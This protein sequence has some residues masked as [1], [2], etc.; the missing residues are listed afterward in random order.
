[1]EKSNKP[2]Y[3]RKWF[4]GVVVLFVFIALVVAFGEDEV[5]HVDVPQGNDTVGE[6]VEG[7]DDQE[8]NDQKLSPEDE[9]EKAIQERI[10]EGDY[11]NAE[12]TQI[13]VN[14]NMGDD[15]NETYI[16]LV[17]FDFTISNRIETGNDV[18]GLYSDDLAATLANKG[19]ENIAEIAIFWDD[20]YNDRNLKYAY[21]FKDGSFYV[22]DIAE[23]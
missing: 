23:E 15:E 14:R 10:D 12:P 7:N 3:K 6:D 16:A 1:M 18:M 2:I 9:I 11:R 19:F 5:D 4:I 8:E 21:K 17:N 20:E 13:R 22:S